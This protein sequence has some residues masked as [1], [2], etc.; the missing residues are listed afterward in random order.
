MVL[1]ASSI[2]TSIQCLALSHHTYNDSQPKYPVNLFAFQYVYSGE[3][4]GLYWWREPRLCIGD[5]EKQL[6]YL[7]EHSH[8]TCRQLW[9]EPRKQGRCPTS[10]AKLTAN[11]VNYYSV[12]SFDGPTTSF[13]ECKLMLQALQTYFCNMPHQ[14]LIGLCSNKFVTEVLGQIYLQSMFFHFGM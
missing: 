4:C 10:I 11:C 1:F 5:K 8:V 7:G 9:F 3:M 13:T 14:L 2:V 6:V 12:I